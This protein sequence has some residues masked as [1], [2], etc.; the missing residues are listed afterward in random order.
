M[1]WIKATLRDPEGASLLP[2]GLLTFLDGTHPFPFSQLSLRYYLLHHSRS[3]A[4][5]VLDLPPEHVMWACCW[6]L[7]SGYQ[8][9][10]HEYSLMISK[11]FEMISA[12]LP[13]FTIHWKQM[14]IVSLSV[15]NGTS[16]GRRWGKSRY[17]CPTC[18][19]RTCSGPMLGTEDTAVGKTGKV[20]AS[21]S[22]SFHGGDRHGWRKEGTMKERERRKE[23]RT[24]RREMKWFHIGWKCDEENT[25]ELVRQAPPRRCQLCWGLNDTK[26]VTGLMTGEGSRRRSSR[27]RCPGVETSGCV[28]GKGR[29][30]WLQWSEWR[31]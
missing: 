24:R 7:F 8:T 1:I 21:Q 16:Q 10:K 17:S 20:P 28:R 2:V 6:G 25:E 11:C 13:L 4:T 5:S 26:P 27:C 29:P 3:T 12:Y 22:S 9:R 14:V 31:G 19:L 23:G 18:S 30:L 15:L